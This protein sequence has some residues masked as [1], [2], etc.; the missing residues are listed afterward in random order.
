MLDRFFGLFKS[1]VATD[2]NTFW[3]FVIIILFIC[4]FLFLRKKRIRKTDSINNETSRSK[5]TKLDENDYHFKLMPNLLTE[6]ELE[7][8]RTLSLII[9][10]YNLTISI[11]PRIADFVE[12]TRIKKK[13]LASG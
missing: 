5:T 11:K 3:I 2:I 1:S 13:N 10:N 8:Y 6:R 4:C 7:F 9:E 12:V